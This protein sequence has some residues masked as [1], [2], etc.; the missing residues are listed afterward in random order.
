MYKFVMFSGTYV[1]HQGLAVALLPPH[2]LFF[3]KTCWEQ[4][5][6]CSCLYCVILA[7][8]TS[9][10]VGSQRELKQRET[11]IMRAK[12]CL[13]ITIPRGTCQ[14]M[15]QVCCRQTEGQ[16]APLALGLLLRGMEAQRGGKAADLV[17]ILRESLSST[18]VLMS[19]TQMISR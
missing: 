16:T 14:Q 2:F 1:I 4:G 6:G 8:N 18:S 12:L 19:S 9:Q 13:G 7:L 10:K 15:C 3:I 5:L 11:P 17:P